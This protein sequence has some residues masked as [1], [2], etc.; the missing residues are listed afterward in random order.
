[1]RKLAIAG[2]LAFA[3]APA[4]RA[5]DAEPAPEQVANLQ[6]QL[7]ALAA[8]PAEE[9]QAREERARAFTEAVGQLAQ[10]QDALTAGQSDVTAAL[11]DVQDQL[12]NAVETS[13]LGRTPEETQWVRAGIDAVNVAVDE[14]GREDL[15][16]ARQ[17]L[18]LAGLHVMRARAIALGG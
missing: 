17:Q 1:M 10:I 11:E 3:V 4:A 5:Q 9:A 15:F 8:L 18:T 16:S 13:S 6:S 2:L 14:I 12:A 7:D